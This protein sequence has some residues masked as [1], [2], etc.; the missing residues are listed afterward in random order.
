MAVPM[1]SVTR[2]HLA[3]W[4]SFPAFLVYAIRAQ[5]QARRSPGFIPGWVGNDSEWSFWTSTVWQNADATR[6]FRNSG[7]HRQAMPT[8]MHWCDEAAYV[9]WEQPD[10]RAPDPAA[11]H[12]RLAREGQLSRVARP[13]ARQQA[14]MRVGGAHPR[15]GSL[16]SPR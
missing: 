7:I 4:R 3:S 2:L 16:L 1:V 6:A 11:A 8:L 14:G 5:R 9:H 10:A 13:S 15:P 12:E